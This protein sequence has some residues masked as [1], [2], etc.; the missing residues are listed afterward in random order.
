MSTKNAYN[1]HYT[2]NQPNSL[3]GPPTWSL[4][5]RDVTSQNVVS[6]GVTTLTPN[7]TG[8]LAKGQNE[9]IV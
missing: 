4:T 9:V 5:D 8:T 1:R 6:G 7:G 3:Q 2:E